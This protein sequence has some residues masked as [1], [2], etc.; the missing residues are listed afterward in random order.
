MYT[1]RS[2][3]YGGFLSRG[4]ICPEGVSVQGCLPK[5]V[6]VQ[7]GLCPEWGGVLSRVVG[8]CLWVPLKGGLCPRGSLSRGVSLCLGVSVRGVSAQG[9]LW[10]LF[11]VWS[12]SRGSLSRGVSV[13][14]GLCPRGSLSGGVSVQGEGSL[15]KGRGLCPGGLCPGCLCCCL[16]QG[17]PYPPE[18]RTT[19]RQI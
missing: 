3:P 16:C 14:G 10:G 19:D 12:L 8:L 6:S 1:V 5:G 4:V 11:P 9:G 7:G 18:N 13:Q 17:D 2:L 15:S